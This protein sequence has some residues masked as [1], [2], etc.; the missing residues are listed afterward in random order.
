MSLP[1]LRLVP[2]RA[3]NKFDSLNET[4]QESTSR[5][6]ARTLVSLDGPCQ[7]CGEKEKRREIHHIDGNPFN[8]DLTNLMR[9]C[10]TCHKAQHPSRNKGPTRINTICK[11]CGKPAITKGLCN[12]HYKRLWR[13]GNPE[14]LL[15]NRLA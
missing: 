4:T 15:I 10:Y 1:K 2:K 8:N 6:W 7:L 3:H 5:E 11:V 14:T 9:L 13:H 12:K